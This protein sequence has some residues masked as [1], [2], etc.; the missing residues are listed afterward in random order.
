MHKRRLMAVSAAVLAML[1]AAAHADHYFVFP[2]VGV[3]Y[4]AA[5]LPDFRG[6]LGQLDVHIGAEYDTGGPRTAIGW[7]LNFGYATTFEDADADRNRPRWW[8]AH[9]APML[10]LSSG[11]NWWTLFARIGFG[12]HVAYSERGSTGYVGGG[13]QIDAAIGSKDAIELFTQAFATF[14]PHGPSLT[15]IGGLRLNLIAF[16][17]LADMLR[18][19]PPHEEILPRHHPHRAVPVD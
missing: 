7:L 2:E 4:G 13:L 17:V 8:R 5:H 14:D 3:G 6:P 1:P 16:V 12:P 11:Y 10:T 9:F 19:R 18:G 15:A